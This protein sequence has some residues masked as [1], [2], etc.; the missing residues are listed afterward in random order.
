M[1]AL[2]R[3]LATDYIDGAVLR[4]RPQCL[5]HGGSIVAGKV[6]PGQ[7]DAG[8]D[9]RGRGG[10]LVEQSTKCEILRIKGIRAVQPATVE[11]AALQMGSVL[12]EVGNIQYHIR[13][14]FILESGRPGDNLAGPD[15]VRTV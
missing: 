7:L 4:I 5:S 3:V 9:R 8:R 10:R 12:A 2:D 14:D 11:S 6:G 13:R 1:V 15:I